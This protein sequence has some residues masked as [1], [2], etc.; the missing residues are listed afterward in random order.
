MKK[1]AVLCKEA[2]DVLNERDAERYRFLRD[3]PDKEC[4]QPGTPCIAI[5][6]AVTNGNSIALNG[7]EA[8]DEVDAAMERKGLLG[9]IAGIKIYKLAEELK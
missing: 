9:T 8:D 4:G 3:L 1:Q 5:A 2:V 6:G 7:N